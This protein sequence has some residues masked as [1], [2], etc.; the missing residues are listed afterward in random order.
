M[1]PFHVHR[2]MTPF[3]RHLSP[4][5]SSPAAASLAAPPSRPGAPLEPTHPA[6]ATARLPEWRKTA[7]AHTNFDRVAWLALV[8]LAATSG[9]GDLAPAYPATTSVLNVVHALLPLAL[10]LALGN[11]VRSRTIPRVPRA[12]ALCSAIWFGVLVASAISADRSQTEAVAALTRPASGLLLAW[13]VCAVCDTA[14]LWRRLAQALAF[15]GLAVALTGLTEATRFVPVTDWIAELHNGPIPIGDVPRVAATLSHPNEAAMFLELTLPLLVALGWTASPRW[16][17]PLTLMALATLLAVALTFSRAGLVAAMAAMCVLALVAA[18]RQ[19][20]ID[21]LLLCV[22]ALAIPLA[23]VW[24]SR[25]DPG[26]DRRLLAGIDESSLQQPART[27]FWSVAVDMVRDHPVLGVGPDNFRWLF[28]AYSDVAVNNLGIHAHDQ[29]LESLA[30][31]GILGLATL[32]SFLTALVLAAA[33]GV[34]DAR[35]DWPLRAALLASLA[36]WLVHALLD[37][38]ERFWPTHVAFWLIVGLIVCRPRTG[39][40]PPISD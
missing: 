2:D 6:P 21:I 28:A 26:L 40:A 39:R 25:M 34:R 4:S 37:D 29:Y 24:G 1:G 22:V 11:A 38:F 10:I 27:A 33:R 31:T 12:L 20:R 15:G 19:A 3:S 14:S 18:R 9:L 36:A 8:C 5:A 35:S 23:L 32:V 7:R 17:A 30:D 13:A 16:R